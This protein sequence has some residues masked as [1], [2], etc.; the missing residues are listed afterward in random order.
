M[1]K[2]AE[3]CTH[4]AL[5]YDAPQ[6][7]QEAY[8]NASLLISFVGS[9]GYVLHETLSGN[10]NDAATVAWLVKDFCEELKR[11]LHVLDEF[12]TATRK[13]G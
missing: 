3:F 8:D 7:F 4:V 12:H 13:E 11:R 9:L 2:I 6:N 10:D 1:A 5:T